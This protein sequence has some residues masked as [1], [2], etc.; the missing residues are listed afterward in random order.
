[1]LIE[2]IIKNGAA[3]SCLILSVLKE[4][5]EL[6]RTLPSYYSIQITEGCP[7]AC[8]YCP[9]PII[10]E[11]VT[12]CKG[13]M[14][15]QQFHSILDKIEQFSE[16]AYINISLWGEPAF[17]SNI[18]DIILSSSSR[19][20]FETI[21]ET[22][23]VG[24][25]K[26]ILNNIAE[27]CKK[28]PIWIVGLD[29]L[30]KTMYERLRG[31]GFEEAQELSAHLQNLF[32]NKVYVQSVRMKE[33]E[34]DVEQFFNHY[35]TR[36][37]NLIIQKYDHFASFLPERKVTDLS[38]LTRHPCWHN[39][40]D[41]Y[42]LLDGT[43]PLCREDLKKSY[44]LGNIFKDELDSVWEKGKSIY[45]DHL[46]AQYNNLCKQCDEYYTYNF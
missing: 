6:L 30:D 43:V 41:I 10:K 21:I 25:D 1:M 22:S 11:N 44:C 36:T 40:R 42:V 8:S 46:S 18:E 34:E 35:K 32:P 26:K 29:A 33:N 3:D 45:T 17:H 20:G 14:E 38:P 5:P 37:E 31:R 23:G 27:K 15:L 4:K 9:Y 39:K 19:I 16:V 12:E 13:E 7:H 2:S 28:S 24:W